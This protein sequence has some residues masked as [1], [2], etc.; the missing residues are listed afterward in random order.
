[1]SES[2]RTIEER[3]IIWLNDIAMD[4]GLPEIMLDFASDEDC[5]SFQTIGVPQ[6][7]K[8]YING[9]RLRNSS[10]R[11]ARVVRGAD[12]S[13]VPYIDAISELGKLTSEVNRRIG[14][15]IDDFTTILNVETSTPSLLWRSEDGASAYGITITIDYKE[16]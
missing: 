12:T 8:E 16:E 14:E 15:R 13:S 9:S 10:F 6:T 1:M 3:L 7:K 11:L 2:T 5:I 4:K